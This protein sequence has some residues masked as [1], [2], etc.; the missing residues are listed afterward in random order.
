MLYNL[1]TPESFIQDILS[2]VGLN[3][4][5][6]DNSFVDDRSRSSLAHS[7]GR[8]AGRTKNFFAK[9]QTKASTLISL[10]GM[11]T[12]LYGALLVSMHSIAAF[13][14]ILPIWMYGTYSFFNMINI[15]FSV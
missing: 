14:I 2:Q 11:E 12:A 6:V 9:K 5:V 4:Y 13:F 8:M 15:N 10:W 1:T 3:S 7:V